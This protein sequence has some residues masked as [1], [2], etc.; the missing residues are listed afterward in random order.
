MHTYMQHLADQ[1]VAKHRGHMQLN[2]NFYQYTLHQHCQDSSPYPWPTP[3]QFRAT[4]TWPGDKPNFQEEACP[5]D[6]QGAAR[7]DDGGAEDDGDM[8]DLLDFFI[9]RG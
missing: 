1:Q 4:V 2:D 3:E 8:V 9:G 7:G 6:A 5:T